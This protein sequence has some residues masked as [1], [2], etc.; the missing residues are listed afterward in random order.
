MSATA[1]KRIVVARRGQQAADD[2]DQFILV[3]MRLV[4]GCLT[5]LTLYVGIRLAPVL[6][7]LGF[8]PPW[9]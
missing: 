6:Q 8:E 5:K 4:Y 2:A 9:V 3:G 1:E 7:I